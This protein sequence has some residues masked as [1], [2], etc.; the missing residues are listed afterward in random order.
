MKKTSLLIIL[1][2]LLVTATL[3]GTLFFSLNSL[4]HTPAQTSAVNAT[5]V[6]DIPSELIIL[7]RSKSNTVALFHI[8]ATLLSHQLNGTTIDSTVTITD[9]TDTQL[10]VLHF[11]NFDQTITLPGYSFHLANA[12][13]DAMQLVITKLSI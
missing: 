1:I 12:T 10:G 7:H 3:L 13:A 8:T 6:T 5:V 11:T 2:M 4:Y 9:D